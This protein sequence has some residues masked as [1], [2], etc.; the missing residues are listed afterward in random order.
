MLKIGQCA[1]ELDP[2]LFIHII[3]GY[4][5]S[6]SLYAYNTSPAIL[7]GYFVNMPMNESEFLTLCTKK[8]ARLLV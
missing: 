7:A 8:I 5:E 3:T 1:L 2:K 4:R 6:D